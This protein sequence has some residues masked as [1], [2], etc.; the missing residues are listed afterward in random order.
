[1]VIGD[2]VFLGT[3]V[4]VNDGVTIGQGS[5]IGAGSLVTKDIPPYAI[6]YGVPARV[7]GD[8]GKSSE[9]P[10]TLLEI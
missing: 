5:V 3:Q 10:M 2:D 6:A 7:V 4:I 9:R 1:V 8:R